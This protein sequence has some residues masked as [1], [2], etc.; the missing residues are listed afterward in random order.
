MNAAYLEQEISTR[1]ICASR[2]VPTALVE[3]SYTNCLC[4]NTF[5]IT[6]P[7]Y[8]VNAPP[9]WGAYTTI[10]ADTIARYKKHDGF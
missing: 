7:L 3:L 9:I 4:P 6:T 10:V 1:I 5:Y 8:Y 2:T